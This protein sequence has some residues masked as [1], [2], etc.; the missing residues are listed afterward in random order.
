MK[1][2]KSINDYSSKFTEPVNQMKVYGEVIFDKKIVKKFYVSALEIFYQI[3]AM[4][5]ETKDI[6]KLSVQSLKSFEHKLAQNLERLVENA[7]SLSLIVEP[8]TMRSNHIT[9]TKWENCLVEEEEMI[10]EIKAKAALI[11]N[12]MKKNNLKSVN[13]TKKKK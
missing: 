11:E 2:N 3:V 12:F 4:I 6:L 10:Q 7:F 8:K 5:E 1:E 13:F 9:I